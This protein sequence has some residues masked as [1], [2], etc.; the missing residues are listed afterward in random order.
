MKCE[1]CGTKNSL[2]WVKLKDHTI[3]FVCALKLERLGAISAPKPR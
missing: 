3:C 2:I 1:H